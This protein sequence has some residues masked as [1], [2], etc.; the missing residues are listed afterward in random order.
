[1]PSAS[2][3]TDWV[4]VTLGVGALVLSVVIALIGN[5]SFGWPFSSSAIWSLLALGTLAMVVVG[6][7]GHNW[8]VVPFGQGIRP[9][10]LTGIGLISMGVLVLT[11]VAVAASTRAGQV[12][13][14]LICLT[15]FGIGSLHSWFFVASSAS[16]LS[17]RR[18]DLPVLQ[19]VGWLFPKLTYAYPPN[20]PGMDKPIPADYVIYTVSYYLAYIVGIVAVG[21]ALFQTRNLE[22]ATASSVPGAVGALGTIGR[23]AAV[24][25]VAAGVLL[26]SSGSFHNLAGIGFV[27]TLIAGGVAMWLLWGFFGR[28]VR[29]SWWLVGLLGL[30]GLGWSGY[31]MA[32]SWWTGANRQPTVVIV[33]LIASFAVIAI[34]AMP[35]TRLYFEF[36]LNPNGSKK[37]KAIGRQALNSEV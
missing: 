12:M 20:A 22:A 32:E 13:T 4:V 29:W 37:I 1:M 15:V 25:S 2:E 36:G 26:A 9:E 16:I 8:K 19:Y 17:D 3:T 34:L 24:V 23:S 31:L 6:F 28:G 27:L 10:L 14:L 5:Y 30:L 11:A 33:A 21:V 18:L 7:V 35:R